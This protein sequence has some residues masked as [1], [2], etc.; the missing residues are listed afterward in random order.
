[1]S[2]VAKAREL[3]IALQRYLYAVGKLPCPG[4]FAT[5]HAL[6]RELGD[7]R[8]QLPDKP[9][10][11]PYELAALV[12]HVAMFGTGRNRK[13]LFDVAPPLNAFKR[14]WELAEESSAYSDN[15]AYV[16][17]FILRVVYQQL[18]YVIH[19][20]RVPAM[21]RRMNALM[22]TDP[23]EHYVVQKIQSSTKD[24]LSAAEALF[25][26]FSEG[27]VYK[28]QDLVGIT[29]PDALRTVLG[30]LA[31]T[32]QQRLAFHKDKL[33]VPSPAEKPYEINS[34]LRYPIIRN[35]EEL[36]CP[37]PQLIGYAAT[38]G[39]FFRWS[40]EDGDA[41]R[42]PFAR[43]NELYTQRILSAA[44]P[45]AEILT[46]EDERALGW[47]GK[48]NDVTAILG[49]SALLVECKLSGLYVEA[50]RTA[51]PEAIIADVR[52]QVAEAKNRRGL[53][54]LYDKCKAIK[55]RSLPAS[56][57]DRYQGVQRVY[58]VL[59]LFDEIQLANSAEVM[60]NIVE[61]E[62]KAN[63][64]EGFEYQIW[65][66]E[67]LDWLV[68]FAKSASMDWIAEKFGAGNRS[69][70]LSSFLA[71]KA[72]Q[73][74]LRL[75]MYLPRGDTRAMRILRSLVSKPNL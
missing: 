70:D 6:L 2:D 13:L 53:F 28:E 65:H 12:N 68:K 64:V 55:S 34:L 56:L 18:P 3:R 73:E 20:D 75:V 45:S 37:Y 41:F 47:Q 24:L 30:L 74:F 63:G 39:L 46:E 54:Q 35:D 48:A 33:A 49:D 58:P 14:L 19:R 31:A 8:F 42:K 22:S 36:Y 23:M 7:N 44:L 50:K 32:R 25:D 5:M 15:P 10:L 17:T 43:C 66:L 51:A 52:K 16:A 1:M 69:M 9:W 11:N 26:R 59:V 21:F 57:M 29:N 62:L 40:G 71:N 27:P 72:G 60:R 61:D 4:A 38:R 67:E